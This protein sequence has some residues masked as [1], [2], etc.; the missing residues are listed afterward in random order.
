MDF[1]MK[2]ANIDL[3]YYNNYVPGTK[4]YWNFGD[5]IQLIAIEMLYKRMGVN[6]AD[7][8]NIPSG[9]LYKYSGDKAVLPINICF[10]KSRGDD[11]C[12]VS[13]NITPVFL[14]V[15]LQTNY[16][17]KAM[18]DFF[19]QHK[20]I[21][22]RDELTYKT[23][24]SYGIDCYLNGCITAAMFPKRE[25]SGNYKK[26]FL[27]DV[28]DSLRGFIPNDIAK[29]AVEMSNNFYGDIKELVPDL[30]VRGHILRQ[31]ETLNSHAK[32]VVTSR[33]HIASPCAS[34]GIP[35]ILVRNNC[36]NTFSWMEK[37]VPVYAQQQFASID[38]NP[39]PV[40]YEEEKKLINDIATNRLKNLEVNRK[41]LDMIT[42]FYLSRE[43]N[44]CIHNNNLFQQAISN[45][46][47]VWN[48]ETSLEYAIWGINDIAE[49]LYYYLRENYPN[50]KLKSVYDKN[51]SIKFHGIQ[52]QKPFE[53]VPDDTAFV[54]VCATQAAK[55]AMEVFTGLGKTRDSFFIVGHTDEKNNMHISA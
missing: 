18:V 53:M 6:S 11:Y 47:T 10:Q 19:S 50:A 54:F 15:N 21:G 27:V 36:P 48:N 7:L 34:M 9:A 40:Y 5:Q 14:A 51:H 39:S 52:T 28:P 17:T 22:C 45:I 42:E 38:W 44:D 13:D 46:K 29:D 2:Y 12:W 20:P 4:H 32:L 23:L 26:T 49:S 37:I 8:I 30:D 55:E 1:I 24:K 43:K 25:E 33:L 31:Y 3:F 35:V 16:L 41:D